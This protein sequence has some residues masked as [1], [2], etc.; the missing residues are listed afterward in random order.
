MPVHTLEATRLIGLTQLTTVGSHT[1]TSLTTMALPLTKPTDATSIQLQALIQ[2]IRYR[3]DGGTATTALGFQLAASAIS[4][5]PVPNASISV[6]AE[7]AG[8]IIQYQ[9]VY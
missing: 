7:A 5:I 3:I 9:W 2:N 1:S 4:T 8:A 6:C